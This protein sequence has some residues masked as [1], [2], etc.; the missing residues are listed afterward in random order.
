M[1]V[2]NEQFFPKYDTPHGIAN[3]ILLPAVMEYNADVYKRQVSGTMRRFLPGFAWHI[4][5]SYSAICRRIP[6]TSGTEAPPALRC[7]LPVFLLR[8]I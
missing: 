5:E 7:R 4:P 8:L 2:F 3:V 6:G 1:F